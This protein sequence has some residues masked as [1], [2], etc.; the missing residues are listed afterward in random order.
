MK[1]QQ[2]FFLGDKKTAKK[3]KNKRYLRLYKDKEYLSSNN[4]GL[5]EQKLLKKV[6]MFAIAQAL[7]KPRLYKGKETITKSSKDAREFLSKSQNSRSCFCQLYCNLVGFDHE[8]LTDFVE[9][10]T[11]GTKDG[12]SLRDDFIKTWKFSH[13]DKKSKRKPK[14]LTFNLKQKE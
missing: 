1:Q 5:A 7:H 10:A 4:N 8:I 2:L 6:I 12:N 3:A 14:Q 13:D 9:Q 11:S